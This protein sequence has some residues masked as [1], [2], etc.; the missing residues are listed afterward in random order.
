MKLH[1][2]YIKEYKLLT[3]FRLNFNPN[4]NV[5]VIIGKNGSGK[6]SV[7]ES[8]S[9]IFSSAYREFLEKSTPFLPFEFELYY[10]VRLEDQMDFGSMFGESHVTYI[11]VT[12]RYSQEKKDK[13]V[14]LIIDEGPYNQNDLI[15]QF[16]YERLLPS[17]VVVYY[18]GLND[19]LKNICFHHDSTYDDQLRLRK[20]IRDSELNISSETLYSGL[21]PL[22][23]LYVD[24]VHFNIAV[25]CLYAFEYNTVVDDYL[26]NQIGIRKP[27]NS[28]LTIL[29]KKRLWN[30]KKDSKEFWGAKGLLRQFLDIL[31]E[32]SAVRFERDEIYF[33]FSLQQWY[34]V[35]EFY[36]EEQK[37]FWLLHMLHASEMLK[38]IVVAASKTNGDFDILHRD[39][40]EGERQLL[41]IRSVAEL[42]SN[43]NT[44]F[45][46]DEPDSYLHPS[47]QRMLFESIQEISDDMYSLSTT[48]SPISLSNLNSGEVFIMEN[49]KAT[50]LTPKYYGRKLGAILFD[51]MGVT[52]RPVEVTKKLD[53]LF[54]LIDDEEFQQ[55]NTLYDE[56]EI[57]LGGDDADLVRARTLIELLNR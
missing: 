40:S 25:A 2:L 54:K 6:S 22:S 30:P 12:L 28:C 23:L 51:M 53:G 15:A 21:R 19:T 27:K 38:D 49:A 9:M 57:L 24:K 32:H 7:L 14:Q 48:H 52:D 50:E 39:F 37:L 36:G 41:T 42:L 4:E 10:S 3:E 46:L 56:L 45:L 1:R 29:L 26:T 16:G 31:K 18:S 17:N 47:W 44:L 13:R 11:G 5:S 34:S 35:R 43:E 33:T 55:A 8:I 20:G